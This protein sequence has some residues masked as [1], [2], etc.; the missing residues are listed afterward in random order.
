MFEN[1]IWAHQKYLWLLLLIP[2]LIALVWIN[3]LRYK[4]AVREF[5]R[6]EVLAGLMPEASLARKVWKNIFLILALMLL[7]IALARPQLGVEKSTKKSKGSEVVIVLDISNSMLARSHPQDMSRLDKAKIAI[8][9]LLNKMENDRVALVIFAGEAA[10]VMPM[11][12][13]YDALRMYLNSV[14]PSYISSQGTAI[15]EALDLA[16]NAFTPEADVNKAIILISDG[17]DL[18]GHADEQAKMAKEKKIRIYTVGVGDKRGN[19]I[20]L[21]GGRTLEYKGQVVISKLHEEYLKKLAAITNGGYV[22]INNRPGAIEA[23]YQDIKKHAT[24]KISAYSRYE[25]IFEYFVAAALVILLF[26]ILFLERKNRF[27]RK[28]KLFEK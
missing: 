24:G 23:I 2:V 1:L 10:M 27:I 25:D 7:I 13:D 17:E 11:T 3:A 14:N 15:G 20:F 4:R 22:N 5:G 18:E 19:P 16:I 21:P 28:I 9:H 12:D 6:R 26:E 8:F